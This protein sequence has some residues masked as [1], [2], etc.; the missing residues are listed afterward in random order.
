ML[1]LRHLE[2][3]RA[4]VKGGSLTEASRL[5]QMSQ[6]AVSKSLRHMEDLLGF[7]LFR[8]VKGG[9][10]QP[11]KEGLSLFEEADKI[12][13]SVS[14]LERYARDLRESQSGVLSVACTPTLSCSFVADAIVRFRSKRP[15]LRVWLQVANTRQVLDLVSSRQADLGLIYAPVDNSEFETIALFQTELVCVMAKDHPLARKEE[16]R[17]ADLVHSA[18]IT[19]VRNEPIHELLRSAF[20]SIDLDRLV[21]IGTNNTVAA[22][23]LVQAESGVAIVEPMSV[24][25]LFPNTVQRAFR[26]RIR[27]TPRAI[28]SRQAP[29]SR[30][31]RSFL[32]T[33]RDVVQTSDAGVP[34]LF[35][36]PGR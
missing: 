5:V 35:R 11:T 14:V 29:L 27:I 22:C 13:H 12:F 30:M 3:F 17:P 9:R 25:E 28:Y 26:P 15:K 4:V 23:S 21:M 2:I 19:N 24:R 18:I 16:I 32:D 10:V 7:Q 36:E 6:P 20:G 1:K 31:A 34:S 33:V 8:R